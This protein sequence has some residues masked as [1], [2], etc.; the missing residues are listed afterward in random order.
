MGPLSGHIPAKVVE[1]RTEDNQCQHSSKHG[2]VKMGQLSGHLHGPGIDNPRQEKNS[3]FMKAKLGP[4]SW[5]SITHRLHKKG[6][7]VN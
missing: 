3:Q 1:K 5:H 6:S 4:L 2:K 7:Q